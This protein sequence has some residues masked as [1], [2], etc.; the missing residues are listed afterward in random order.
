MTEQHTE[1]WH[2]R[3]TPRKLRGWPKRRTWSVQGWSADEEGRDCHPTTDVGRQ[4]RTKQG[5]LRYAR[6]YF[7]HAVI[8]SGDREVDY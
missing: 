7:P 6:R 2:R 5:A 1:T 8:Y 3:E 4:F